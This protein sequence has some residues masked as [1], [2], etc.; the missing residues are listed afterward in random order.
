MGCQKLFPG[1]QRM[2]EVMNVYVAI[3]KSL[4]NSSE[5][6]AATKPEHDA[7]W[8]TRMSSLRLAG[9]MLSDDGATRLGQVIVLAVESRA[10]AEDIVFNDPF[11][12]AGLFSSC[13][14]RRFNISVDNSGQA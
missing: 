1:P 2:R 5:L 8:A 6:R 3:L 4:E 11:Y 12:K 9:P 13:D 10:A 14:I 7:Y